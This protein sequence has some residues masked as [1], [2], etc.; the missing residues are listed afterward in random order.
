MKGVA[1]I[2]DVWTWVAIDADRKLVP[3]WLVGKR[4]AGYA[5]RFMSDVAARLQSSAAD[6][7]RP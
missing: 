3:S 6:H 7:G 2:G 4:D 5:F 1:G